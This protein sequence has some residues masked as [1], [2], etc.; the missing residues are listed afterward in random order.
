MILPGTSITDAAKFAEKIR[1]LIDHHPDLS[2][3]TKDGVSTIRVTGSI[4]VASVSAA[5][6]MEHGMVM[7]AADRALYLAKEGGRNQVC[8]F[9]PARDVIT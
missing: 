8:V 9:D 2:Y 7:K 4:G 5:K 3:R 1:S 6:A